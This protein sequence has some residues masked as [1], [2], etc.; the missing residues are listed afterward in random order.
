MIEYGFF[1]SQNGDRKYNSSDFSEYFEGL[2]GDGVYASVGEKLRVK[3]GSGMTVNVGT[4]RAK[5]LNR[6]VKNTSALSL[7][8][9]VASV[10]HPRWDAVIVKVDLD[11]RIGTIEIIQ[12]TPAAVPQK[13]AAPAETNIGA[14]VLAY[15]YVPTGA[16][17]I[18]AARIE[19]KRGTSLCPWVTGLVNQIDGSGIISQYRA[20]IEEFEIEA[21]ESI[22]RINEFYETMRHQLTMQTRLQQHCFR[23]GA[24][25][26]TVIDFINY[27]PTTMILN[28]YLNGVFLRQYDDWNY[29]SDN[30][31]VKL[32]HTFADGD[33]VDM[34][35]TMAY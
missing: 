26:D 2:I 8:I 15:I 31:T 9:P 6:Y 33:F 14:Y 17:N 30:N 19:D 12:G 3:A 11:Q 5:I 18:S 13:P 16:T 4:G 35:F 22:D 21:K 25:T 1:D 34:V 23:L 24:E 27:D 29:L 10:E 32:Y 7:D 20:M 28:I